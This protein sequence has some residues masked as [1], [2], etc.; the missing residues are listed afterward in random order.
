MTA[1]RTRH[2]ATIDAVLVLLD[3]GRAR[4]ARTLL[5]GL[6]E[7]VVAELRRVA[8]EAYWAGYTEGRRDLAWEIAHG[9]RSRAP[10]RHS[11]QCPKPGHGGEP[12][13]R[14]VPPRHAWLADRVRDPVLRR[15]A[16]DALGIGDADLEVV[17]DGR[18]RL[19]STMWKRLRT[20]LGG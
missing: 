4:M 9:K 16:L 18:A 1:P 8:D 19:S 14:K 13:K 6:A 2:A 10:E 20:E 12:A 5:E 7:D 15:R 17:L 11:A 3:G